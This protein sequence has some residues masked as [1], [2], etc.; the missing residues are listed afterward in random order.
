M[1]EDVQ[2]LPLVVIKDCIDGLIRRLRDG[3]GKNAWIT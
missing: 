2:G 1:E 3:M